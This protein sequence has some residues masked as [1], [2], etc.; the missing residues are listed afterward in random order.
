[1]FC[2]PDRDLPTQLGILDECNK[3]AK[4]LPMTVRS[5]YI[6]KPDKAIALMMTYTASKG[7]N[8]NEL[9]RVVDSVQS[10]AEESVATPVSLARM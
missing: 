5:V 7:R 1:M 2:D 8:F 9:I 10:T 6:L 4:G 3:D